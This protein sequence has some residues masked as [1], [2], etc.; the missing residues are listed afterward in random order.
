MV[1]EWVSFDVRDATEKDSPQ[2]MILLWH[3]YRGVV[4]EPFE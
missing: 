3:I 4:V 1:A 2:G